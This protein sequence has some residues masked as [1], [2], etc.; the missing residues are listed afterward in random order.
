MRLMGRPGGMR[1]GAGGRFEGF[2]RSADLNLR[3]W[4]Q[5]LDSTHQLL[6]YGKGGGFNRSM[7]SAGPGN[8][9]GP[10]MVANS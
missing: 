1:G 5:V 6:P 3:I 9:Q 10:N 7:H 2:Q 8:G 4:I